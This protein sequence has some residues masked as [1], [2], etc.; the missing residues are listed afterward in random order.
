[1]LWRATVFAA[2][3][4]L[5]MGTASA[6]ANDDRQEKCDGDGA[7][8][9]RVIGAIGGAI[10]GNRV[11][12]GAGRIF[13]TILGGALGGWIGGEIGRALDCGSKKKLATA[14][15]EA[16]ESDQPR[17]WENPD[18]GTSGRVDVRPA[19]P[20]VGAKHQGQQCRT[21]QQTVRLSDGRVETHHV[22]ACRNEDGSWSPVE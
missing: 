2:L 10:V 15:G 11:G 8:I 3:S 21:V 17:D 18:A 5:S 7:T 14:T 6:R 20:E 22:Q 13:A 16:L 19:L 4:V 9:G 12:R 1:M